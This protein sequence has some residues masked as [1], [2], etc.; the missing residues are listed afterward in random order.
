MDV[1]VGL[2]EVNGERVRSVDPLGA[3]GGVVCVRSCFRVYENIEGN[4]QRSWEPVLR[5]PIAGV[6]VATRGGSKTT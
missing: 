6:F 5:G 4:A 2:C 1:F 3:I